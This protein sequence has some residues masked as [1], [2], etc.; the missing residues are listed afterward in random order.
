MTFC[1]NPTVF[2]YGTRYPLSDTFSDGVVQ[3]R[4]GGGDQEMI[5]AKLR[6]HDEGIGAKMNTSTTLDHPIAL[7]EPPLIVNL[8][9]RLVMN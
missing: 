9:L 7:R 3:C 4:A 8:D 1:H 6:A 5:E 2:V